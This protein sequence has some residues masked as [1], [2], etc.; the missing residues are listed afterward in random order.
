MRLVETI[1][2]RAA[3]P[4]PH[5]RALPGE[6]YTDP[7]LYEL[8]A[9]R[10][11]RKEWICVA[12]AEQVPAAGDWLA[13]D[14]VG[15]PLVLVRDNDGALRALSRVCAHRAQDVLNNA[16]ER[17]GNSARFTCPYHLWSYRLD[18][19]CIGAPDMQGSDEF[20]P[21]ACG[22]GTFALEQ[23]QGFVFISL[24]PNPPP[25]A[26]AVRGLDGVMG[27]VDKSD[28]QIARTLEWGEKPVKWKDVIENAAMC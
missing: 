15:E 19:S 28:W 4:L 17:R 23:W 11:F 26:D 12:R 9:E 14:L 13:I 3:R 1:R 21:A 7:E 8:E 16:T 25:F 27:D 18:G 20:D 22:L 5:A 10:I 2:E 6:C 24:D